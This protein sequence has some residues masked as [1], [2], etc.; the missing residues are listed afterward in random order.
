[1][2]ALEITQKLISYPTITPKECGI[3][4]YIKSLFPHFK[5]LEC[6]ENGVKNLFLYH[7]FNP[8]KEHA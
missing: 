8:P 3:F 7:I 6:G 1:M 2:N 4:E 5:T